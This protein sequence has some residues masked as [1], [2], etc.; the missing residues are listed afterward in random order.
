[1]K[2][3]SASLWE[4]ESTDVDGKGKL[5]KGTQKWEKK[6]PKEFVITMKSDSASKPVVFILSKVGA[7]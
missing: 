4:G 3:K 7:K 6:S 2:I 1:V 5:T